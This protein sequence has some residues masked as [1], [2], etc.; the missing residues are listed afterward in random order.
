MSALE[1]FGLAMLLCYFI[2][3]MPNQM[4]A[5]FKLL[6]LVFFTGAYLLSLPLSR[7]KR[8][9]TLEFLK[10]KRPS[11]QQTLLELLIFLTIFAYLYFGVSGR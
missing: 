6:A 7:W 2:G 11:L 10:G 5:D 4:P 3:V 8:R 9:R 1:W